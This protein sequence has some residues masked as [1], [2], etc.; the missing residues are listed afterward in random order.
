[1][2]PIMSYLAPLPGEAFEKP[3]YAFF[4][5]KAMK[6]VW[7]S[8]NEAAAREAVILFENGGLPS[9]L[10]ELTTSS[11]SL[12]PEA[13][14]RAVVAGLERS[15]WSFDRLINGENIHLVTGAI[16]ELTAIAA[17]VHKTTDPS[18]RWFGKLA[19]SAFGVKTSLRLVQKIV[20]FDFEA[21]MR[22]HF[23]KV[24]SQMHLTFEEQIEY[25]KKNGFSTTNL[26]LLRGRK[27]TI[28]PTQ[29]NDALI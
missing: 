4:I 2:I 19:S 21:F 14:L 8:K 12:L 18:V 29:R 11:G 15:E 10:G 23:T 7:T 28:T 20:P 26:T 13:I 3:G 24:E 22:V 5:S 17:K 16:R 9:K 6:A 1:M 25:G 27:K